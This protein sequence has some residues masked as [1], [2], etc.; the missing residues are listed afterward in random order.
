MLGVRTNSDGY[1][2]W[3]AKAW[4]LFTP[5]KLT[6]RVRPIAAPIANGRLLIYGS[7][8]K[9]DGVIIDTSTKKVINSFVQAEMLLES[10]CSG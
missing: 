10:F 9:H 3:V 4:N 5:D 1:V 2:S 6:A 8:N 7:P